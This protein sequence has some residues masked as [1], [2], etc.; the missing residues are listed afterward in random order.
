MD[1]TTIL[2]WAVFG[3]ITFGVWAL[4]ALLSDKGSRATERLDELRDPNLR[5]KQRGKKQGMGAVLEAAAPALSKALQPKTEL[6]QNQLKIRLS[7]AGF[8]APEAP[9]LY[10]AIKFSMLIFGALIGGGF[11]MLMYGATQHGYTAI[12]LAAGAGFYVP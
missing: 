5:N 1:Y 2:P 4:I 3:G 12:V 7:N 9:Q 8:H 6:E 10:L 11:G